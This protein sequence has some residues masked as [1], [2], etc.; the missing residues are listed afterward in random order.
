VDEDDGLAGPGRLVRDSLAADDDR[1][2]L[3][4]GS[5]SVPIQ[6]LS[7]QLGVGMEQSAAADARPLPRSDEA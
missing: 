5:P 3:Q 2:T 4:P 7:D 6:G 1:P